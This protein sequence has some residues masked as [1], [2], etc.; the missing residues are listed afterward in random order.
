MNGTLQPAP[1]RP[2]QARPLP[3]SVDE[4]ISTLSAPTEGELASLLALP[5]EQQL[6]R[7]YGHTLREIAQQPVTWAETSNRMQGE[8]PPLA[9]CMDGMPAVV[10]TG[11]GSS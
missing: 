8:R 9:E 2:P 3:S 6:Q 11:S 4:W 7:G 10:F 1:E 5:W